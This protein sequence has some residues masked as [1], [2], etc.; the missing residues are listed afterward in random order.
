M[1]E[2]QLRIIAAYKDA[3]NFSDIP[4]Q[5]LQD[6]ISKKYGYPV[7]AIIPVV[8]MYTTNNLPHTIDLNY[9]INILNYLYAGIYTQ[10]EQY[11]IA[12]FLY[13]LVNNTRNMERILIK[14]FKSLLSLPS[15]KIEIQ[16]IQS[17][18]KY[19]Y[20]R[21]L[22]EQPIAN[23][24]TIKKILDELESSIQSPVFYDLLHFR[25]T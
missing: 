19:N 2:M 22:I 1:D 7:G 23:K 18:F 13:L 8:S 21:L 3:A 6:Y 4:Q 11:I 14:R 10:N 17:I 9:F 24:I 5:E 25:E 20:V 15:E 12:N 16:E